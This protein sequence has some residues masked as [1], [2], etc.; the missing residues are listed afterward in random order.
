MKKTV[1]FFLLCVMTAYSQKIVTVDNAVVF[2]EASVPLFIPVEAKNESVK[3][4]LNIK[5]GHVFFEIPMKN[6]HFERSLME[7]HFND[8]YLETHKY[9]KAKFKGTIEKFDLKVITKIPKTFFIKGV[10]EIHGKSK[11]ITVSS[12]LYK[13][14]QGGIA[15]FSEFTL[16]SEDFNIE[17]PYLIREKIA[18]TVN[19]KVQTLF[20]LE[21]I[22]P[23]SITDTQ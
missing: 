4:T 12:S 21:A 23:K 20:Q 7:S 9:P 22:D 17:I 13:T 6:F 3:A 19:V 16:L 2:F 10:I 14:I 15:L 5:R 1:L 8:Y 11:P 18:K